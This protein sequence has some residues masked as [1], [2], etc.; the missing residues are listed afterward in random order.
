M[1]ETQTDKGKRAAEKSGMVFSVPVDNRPVSSPVVMPTRANPVYAE[2]QDIVRTNV[3]LRSGTTVNINDY[4]EEVH[5]PS[6]EESDDEYR[7]RMMSAP[8]GRAAGL[9]HPRTT[10]ANL[11]TFDSTQVA[12]EQ[13][14]VISPPM[15]NPVAAGLPVITSEEPN[16]RLVNPGTV[17]TSE[18]A[19]EQRQQQL[20]AQ[21]QQLD[22]EKRRLET[23]KSERSNMRSGT[24]AGTHAKA[25]EKKEDKK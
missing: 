23:S 4:D 17:A 18:Q 14:H 3:L 20:T 22:E 16:P 21:Q 12:A 19:L 2:D 25:A 1:A 11:H 6:V 10:I 24:A 13:P 9:A 8:D 7:R 15:I 5:G